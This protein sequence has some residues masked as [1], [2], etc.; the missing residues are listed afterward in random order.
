MVEGNQ[1][2]E[3]TPKINAK[4]IEFDEISTNI[5]SRLIEV[6]EDKLLY[7]LDNYSRKV[8]SSKLWITYLS[9]G[10]TLLISLLTSDF[11]SFIGIDSSAWK[12][13]FIIGLIVCGF[14]GVINFFWKRPPEVKKIILQIRGEQE[15]D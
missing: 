5:K 13:F 2:S 11:K 15:V 3:E 10:L 4:I 6:S 7:I 14:V 12:G 9:T 1:M 8:S